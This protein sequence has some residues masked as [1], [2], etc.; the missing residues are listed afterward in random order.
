[1][2]SRLGLRPEDL[3]Y[4]GD[5]PTKDFKGARDAGWYSVRIRRHGTLQQFLEPLSGFEPDI[6]ISS[7][8]EMDSA[9]LNIR[10]LSPE[11]KIS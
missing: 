9:L 5:N 6:E 4:V 8:D 11:I 10:S 7:F 3:V 1:M 2:Q